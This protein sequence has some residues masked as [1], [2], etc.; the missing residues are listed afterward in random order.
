[1]PDPRAPLSPAERIICALDVPALEDAMR[2]VDSLEGSIRWFKIGMELFTREG[3]R[4]VEAV[5]ERGAGVFLDLKYHDIPATAERAV[6]SA[7]ALGVSL[8]TVHAAGGA[9]MLEA[10]ARGRDSCQTPPAILAVTVLTSLDTNA[11][12]AA[13]IGRPV[14]E[15]VL[16]T[17]ALAKE[18]GI[19]GLVASPRE[20]GSLRRALGDDILIVTPGV[21]LASGGHDDHARAET[22]QTAVRDGADLLVIGRPIRD[23]PDPRVA[24]EVFA[25]AIGQGMASR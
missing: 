12:A 8:L 19:D 22:P 4:A 23:A 20:V 18:A 15:Q 13:G 9:A 5:L 17:G 25:Q 2:L 6:A 16:A 24:A 10:C 7:G 11:L 14:E 1:M 21:R 3:P